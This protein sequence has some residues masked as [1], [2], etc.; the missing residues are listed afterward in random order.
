VVSVDFPI[1]RR[2]NKAAMVLDEDAVA[3][4]DDPAE[5]KAPSATRMVPCSLVPTFSFLSSNAGA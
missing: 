4:D 3:V 5:N 2:T 1:G